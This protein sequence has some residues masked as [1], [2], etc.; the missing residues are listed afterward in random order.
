MI[1]VFWVLSFKPTFSLSSFTCI[2][3]LFSSSS[4][5]AIRV[6]SSAYLR[7]LIFLLAILISACASKV[8]QHMQISMCYTTLIEW[9]IK[10]MIISTDAENA[11]DKVKVKVG[12]SCLTLW[13]H[14]L[15]SPLNSP[16]QNTGV[17]SLFLLQGILPTQG[18][19]WGL[20]HCGQ[21]LYQMSNKGSPRILEWV[22]YIFSRGS[23]RPRNQT[24]VI[25]VQ[26]D[27]FNSWRIRGAFDKTQHHF[28]LKLLKIEH[29][30]NRLQQHNRAYMPNSQL[31]S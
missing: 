23:S 31:T 30:R 6:V 16:G 5:S 3:R 28:I 11:L 10:I 9:K 14:G 26:A 19:N 20:P 1:L 22:A 4:L 27:S 8:V 15:Y 29:Q 7:L 18:S 12:Q 17:S 25:A 24:S 2:K 13:P 21:I